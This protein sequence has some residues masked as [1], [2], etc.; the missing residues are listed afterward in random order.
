MQIDKALRNVSVIGSSWKM[1]RKIAT[2]FILEISKTEINLTG[3]VGNGQI[4]WR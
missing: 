2:L 3:E 1:G 4:S